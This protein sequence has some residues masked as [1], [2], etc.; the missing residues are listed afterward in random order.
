MLL[1]SVHKS[2]GF[3]TALMEVLEKLRE[4]KSPPQNLH[5]YQDSW[6]EAHSVF[7]Y[8]T[9]LYI[10]AS[11]LK[12][13]SHEILH[14]IFASHYLKPKTERYSESK[15][16]DFGG[17]YG[18][19][20][21]LQLVLA[22]ERQ[23]LNSPAGELIKRQADR[24][25]VPL[26]SIIEAD[27]L[28]FMMALITDT[29]HWFPQMLFY[30]SQT[31]CMFFLRATQHRHFIKLAVITGIMDADLLR[32]AIDAGLERIG[33]DRWISGLR[34]QTIREKMNFKKLDTLA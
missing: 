9:F 25:D 14:N 31:E 13:G 8:E 16:E 34:T 4:I 21:I 19:S 24:T 23:R 10:V 33:I 7:V 20:E 29:V 30:H 22:S 11:L 12:T 2:E 27:L 18:H 6:F 1:E 5:S 32:D 26:S 28:S 17:F 3:S 15:F